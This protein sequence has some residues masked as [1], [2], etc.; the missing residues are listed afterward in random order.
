MFQSA[1][2]SLPIATALL[3]SGAIYAC[4]GTHLEHSDKEHGEKEHGY[5]KESDE[6]DEESGGE[7][8]DVQVVTLDA[9]PAAV[10][11]A[12]AKIA[13]PSTV[14]KVERQVDEGAVRFEI[15]FE[16]D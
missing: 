4:A 16:A 14:T 2:R 12:F 8:E 13:A 10:R 1:R 9:A 11:E 6:A 3:L 15:D 7:E 5:A